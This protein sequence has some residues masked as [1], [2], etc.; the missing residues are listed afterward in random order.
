MR[1]KTG[2]VFAISYYMKYLITIV[3]GVLLGLHWNSNMGW[4]MIIIFG[5]LILNIINN[6]Q[7]NRK[8]LR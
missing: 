2:I 1:Y 4:C 7:K 5:L 8:D 3:A 6:E